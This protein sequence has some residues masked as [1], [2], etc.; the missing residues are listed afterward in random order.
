MN[1]KRSLSTISTI[2]ALLCFAGE[3]R[4]Q[5]F[6]ERVLQENLWN[7]GIGA[8]GIR[9]GSLSTGEATLSGTLTKGGFR[10][11]AEGEDQWS[12]GAQTHAV[13]HLD[14]FSMAG[15][16]GFT[17]MQGN[18]MCG[19]MSI[20]PGYYPIEVWEF[21]P[22]KKTLQSYLVDG[23]IA[24][25]LSDQ[26]RLGGHFTMDSENYSKR[27]D[28]RHTNYRLDLECAGGLM[29]HLDG[30]ALELD[31]I[32]GKNSESIFAE[33]VGTAVSSYPAFLDKGQMYGV[34]ELWNGS[35]IHLSEAGV[36]GLPIREMVYGAAL[37]AG[38]GKSLFASLQYRHSSGRAGEKEYIW[39]EFPGNRLDGILAARFGGH[40][41]RLAFQAYSQTN[42]ESVIDKTTSGGITTI[43]RYGTNRILQRDE[44]SLTPSY[45]YDSD[46]F[47]VRAYLEIKEQISSAS[48]MYPYVFEQSLK[49]VMG[50]FTGRLNVG[51]FEFQAGLSGGRGWM[52]ERERKVVEIITGN[53]PERYAEGYAWMAEYNTIPRLGAS[54]EA[55][56]Y[57]KNGTAF[58][59][60]AGDTFQALGAVSA[61]PG[62]NRT[63]LK[64]TTGIEF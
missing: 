43:T 28:V 50:G 59:G 5:S 49:S 4:A 40:T 39:F 7:Y 16:F 36:S 18:G 55:R 25:D 34:Y 37:E 47:M 51:S 63:E 54:L 27:K 24:V 62:A 26:F 56:W 9:E 60:L 48:Q 6:F 19:P 12:V 61:L 58:I 13:R 20:H 8:S 30:F 31:A 33:Q 38:Y 23:A 52:D 22:G 46:L 15:G 42:N 2:V 35:G 57:P 64:L 45:E 41:A 53:K 3:T 14:K 10:N 44:I 17:Q 11:A 29:W 21:T 32:L 1:V